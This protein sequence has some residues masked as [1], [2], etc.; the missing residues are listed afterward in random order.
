VTAASILWT[1]L[2]GPGH[3]ACSLR[4]SD[5]GW[6]LEG[7]AVFSH[8][9]VPARL[10]YKLSC[11]SSWRTRRG[12]VEGWIGTRPVEFKITRSAVGLWT[13]N[14]ALAPG[15]Q[16]CDDLDL[17]FS[18]ATNLSQL[19]RLALAEGQAADAPVAW[20]DVSS[21]TLDLLLQ[22][23]ERRSKLTYWYE[24]PRFNYAALLEV[25]ALGFVHR[26][27]GLWEVQATSEVEPRYSHDG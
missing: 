18:P 27:P 10:G 25:S 14:G 12:E 9:G 24:A 5:A 16:A 8:A 21:G 15:L 2:D 19:R 20:L 17:G 26:Y 4:E 1:R 3:D 7:C 22:R 6:Q 11:D 23:Y 13:C